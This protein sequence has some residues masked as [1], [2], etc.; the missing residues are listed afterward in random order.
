MG[1]DLT[2]IGNL[3]E[4]FGKGRAADFPPPSLLMYVFPLRSLALVVLLVESCGM[5]IV[6]S[7]PIDY[8]RNPDGR[9]PPACESWCACFCFTSVLYEYVIHF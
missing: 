3:T 1:H 6:Q 9:F 8:S 5:Y 2:L 4:K 7:R